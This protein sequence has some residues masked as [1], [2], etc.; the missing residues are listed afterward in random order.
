M[1]RSHYKYSNKIETTPDV[2]KP[3]IPLSYSPVEASKQIL[4]KGGLFLKWAGGKKQL[5]PEL[6][7]HI[8]G[9]YRRYI[10]PFV[11]AGA[12]FFHLRP[13]EAVLSDSNEE[14][15]NAYKAV[16]DNVDALIRELGRYVNDEKFYYEVRALKPNNQVVFLSA[17]GFQI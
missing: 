6:M 2:V 7:G 1:M 17:K 12:L 15:I 5:L 4:V 10:E 8:P 9:T 3:Q 11:G 14:L 13:P 16:R